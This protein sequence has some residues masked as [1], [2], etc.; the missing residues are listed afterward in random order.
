MNMSSRLFD[1][2]GAGEEKLK[3]SIE[4]GVGQLK[5]GVSTTLCKYMLLPYLKVHTPQ[6][7]HKYFD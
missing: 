4:L 6:P 7:S 3:R 2:L 5:I 1:A